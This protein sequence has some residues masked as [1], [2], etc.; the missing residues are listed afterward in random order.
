M[1]ILKLKAST[2]IESLVASIIVI[3]IFFMAIDI[4]NNTA[5][6]SNKVNDFSIRQEIHQ[7]RY[8]A[9][10]NKLNIPFS[11][12]KKNWLISVYKENGQTLLK[13]E[14]IDNGDLNVKILSDE[15]H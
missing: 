10:T 3:I 4:I 15:N 7:I 5:I 8:K 14:N 12:S 1:A 11:V 2:L 9:M 6:K 13:W